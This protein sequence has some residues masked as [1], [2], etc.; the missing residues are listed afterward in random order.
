MSRYDFIIQDYTTH[1]NYIYTK[2][3]YNTDAGL[4]S[5]GGI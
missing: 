3:L 1:K 4:H 5:L 2:L